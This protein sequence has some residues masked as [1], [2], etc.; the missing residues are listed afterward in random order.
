[1]NLDLDIIWKFSYNQKNRVYSEM[2]ALIVGSSSG[3]R[4]TCETCEINWEEL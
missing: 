3:I 2:K 1:M 4:A